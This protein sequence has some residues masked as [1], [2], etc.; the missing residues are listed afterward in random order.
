MVDS[1]IAMRVSMPRV[2]M[3]RKKRREKKLGKGIIANAVG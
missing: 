3:M 2:I 1:V